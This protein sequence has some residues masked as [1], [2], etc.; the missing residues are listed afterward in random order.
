MELSCSG[1]YVA[2]PLLNDGSILQRQHSSTSNEFQNES[3]CTE[4][5]YFTTLPI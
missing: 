1:I 4:S 3:Y 5:I 2:I